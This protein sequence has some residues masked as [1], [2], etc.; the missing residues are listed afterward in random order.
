VAALINISVRIQIHQSKQDSFKRRHEKARFNS[1]PTKIPTYWE[2]TNC[3]KLLK[4]EEFD[5]CVSRLL[6][7]HACQFVCFR[8]RVC[9]G[10]IH[11]IPTNPLLKN[12]VS[13]DVSSR[14]TRPIALIIFDP[15]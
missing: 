3:V 7:H 12:H 2:L 15:V 1:A 6:R 13:M 14:E 10:N 9:K 8:I 5:R 11:F 4:I